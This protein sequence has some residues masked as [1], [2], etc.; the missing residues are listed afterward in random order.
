MVRMQANPP[1]L[2]SNLLYIQRY[3]SQ[4]RLVSEAAYFFTNM[5]SAESFIMNIDAKSLSME[6]TEFEK[7]MEFAQAL[8]FGSSDSD[9]MPSQSDQIVGQHQ[10]TKHLGTTPQTQVPP[11]TLE[12]KSRNE[13]SHPK[14]PYALDK[15]PSISDLENHGANML[16]KD[17]NAKQVFMDFPYLYA[18]SGDLTIGD[19][20]GLLN[21]YKQLVFKYVCLSKGMGV[22]V[23]PPSSALQTPSE[24]HTK[25]TKEPEDSRT[26]KPNDKENENIST[27]VE[28]S[29]VI[30]KFG[31]EKSGS[32][33]S[34]EAVA[35]QDE[36]AWAS[37]KEDSKPE[38]EA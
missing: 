33:S 7:N 26:V 37:T 6:D 31:E 23:T 36:M 18:K 27:G 38:D 4:S 34:Q 28:V 29:E 32:M 9:N 21:N 15:V 8:L 14:D 20:D 2:H 16:M 12:T 24:D 3:R 1:Q 5:L 22:P 25:T 13:K 11:Q 19:V 35:S 10:E 17:E 30:P